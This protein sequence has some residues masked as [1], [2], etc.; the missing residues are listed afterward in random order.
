MPSLVDTLFSSVLNDPNVQA[1]AAAAAIGAVMGF[2]P[3]VN[4][5]NGYSE[6]VFTPAQEDAVVAYLNSMISGSSTPAGTPSTST[7]TGVSAKVRINVKMILLRVFL[8]N[9]WYVLAGPFVGGFL[10]GRRTAK[11]GRGK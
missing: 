5:G 3:A 2:T 11:I 9:Y 4:N 6:I 10:T 1:K 7:S 8:K